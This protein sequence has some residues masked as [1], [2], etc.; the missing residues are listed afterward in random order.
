MDDEPLLRRRQ[1]LALAFATLGA[2]TCL[3]VFDLVGDVRAVLDNLCIVPA[4]ALWR[5]Y[6][7]DW[8]ERIT[9]LGMGA[10]SFALAGAWISLRLMEGSRPW[11]AALGGS[12]VATQGPAAFVGLLTMGEAWGRLV[13]AAVLAWLVCAPCAILMANHVGHATRSR[14]SSLLLAAYRRAVWLDAAVFSVLLTAM[15]ASPLLAVRDAWNPERTLAANTIVLV[16]T[17]FGGVAAARAFASLTEL[18]RLRRGCRPIDVALADDRRAMIV[19]V[20]IGDQ[21]ERELAGSGSAYRDRRETRTLL[22]GDVA[23]ALSS[24]RW[25]LGRASALVIVG[26]GVLALDHALF[27]TYWSS[28]FCSWP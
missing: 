16:A 24:L 13:V 2:V 28:P 11:V 15:Y 4:E 10:L 9:A 25:A 22:K 19:D 20:G 6:T 27:H 3:F 1:P 17:V 8:F 7:F 18:R 23:R 21:A 14:P 12:L 5:S 26:T